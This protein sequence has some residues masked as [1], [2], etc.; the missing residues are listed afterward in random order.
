MKPDDFVNS[1]AGRCLRAPGGYWTFVPDPLPPPIEYDNNLVLL[2]SR[3]DQ[4]VGQLAGTGRILP[5]PHLLVGPYVR[6]E[7]VLSSRIEGT[8]ASLNDLFLFEAASKPRSATS[9]VREVFNYVQALEY[10]LSRLK[11]LPLSL[12][13]VTETHKLLMRGVRGSRARPGEFRRSQNWIGSPGCKLEEATYI[14]PDIIQMNSVLS[15][16]ERYLHSPSKEPPL[17]QCALMHYHFEAIHP[18]LDGNGR[19]GR[20]L[21]TLFLCERGILPQ[22]LLY[23]SAFFERFRDEYYRSLLNVSQKGAWTE[24]ISFFLRG[25]DHQA[26][27]AFKTAEQILDLQARYRQKLQ[28]KKAPKAALAILE[29]LFRNPFVYAVGASKKWNVNYRT[30]VTAIMRMVEAGILQEVTGRKRNRLFCCT[31]L[32]NLIEPR[33]SS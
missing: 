9:D 1:N 8:Q 18:F 6:R 27:D 23:L 32:L 21:I 31:E 7:A 33:E 14:P 10:G 4:S 28:R 30:A 13:L 2:L 24:W 16:W 19:I 26:T 17:I 15:D 25:V 3:A 20:L 22:P 11:E 12:R 5:N 29:D